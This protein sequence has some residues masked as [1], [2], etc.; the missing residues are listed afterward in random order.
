MNCKRLFS[1]VIILSLSVTFLPSIAQEKNIGED[2]KPA[3]TESADT[4]KSTTPDSVRVPIIPIS[5]IGTID[6][7][8][9]IENVVTDTA[10]NWNDYS[11][12]NDIIAARGNVFIR[13]LGSVGQFSSLSIGGLDERSVAFLHDGI[14]LNEPLT[15]T[16]NSYW[17][18][19]EQIERVEIETG[20]RAFLYGFNSTGGAINMLTKSF[21]AIKPYSRIRYSESLYEQAF[22]DG[23]V[24]QNLTRTLNL[25]LGVQRYT[26]DGRFR[27]SD[28]DA[29]GVRFKARF[30][31]S[32]RWNIFFSEN[33]TQTQLGLFGGVNDTLTNPAFLF[34]RLQAVI[35]NG[36]SYEK[37]TRHDLQL[38]AA[39]QLFEDT[40]DVTTLTAY[41]ST[42]LREFRNEENR[43]NPDGIFIQDN[44]HLHWQGMKFTQHLEFE[45]QSF[46]LGA[47]V[48]SRQIIESPA[49][50][51]RVQTATSV[52][53]KLELQPLDLVR[54]ALYARLDN[55][56]NHSPLSYGGDAT[57]S[58]LQE[59]SL[60]AGYSRSSRFPT[61]QELYWR[62]KSIN[63]PMGEVEPESHSVAEAGTRIHLGDIF[64]FHARY[65]YRIISNAIATDSTSFDAPFP[66]L[67]FVVRDNIQYNG[68]ELF[69]SLR[70]W[71]LYAEGT[72][73]YLSL[74]ENGSERTLF[75]KWWAAGGIYFWD[76]LFHDNL[77]LKVGIRGRIVGPQDGMEFNPEAMMFVPSSLPEL[78]LATAVDGILLAHIGSAYI[79]FIWQNLFDNN[80]VVTPFYPMPDRAVRFGI[81]WEL[82]D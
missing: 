78:G 17:Y 10:A 7:T 14:L 57:L 26:T 33:Y 1:F 8:I 79:H 49:T 23:R 80:Y 32:S 6:R 50:G 73:H 40:T 66:G 54:L 41:Y 13:D 75:P 81:S 69:S 12:L 59:I 21:K 60:F 24:S 29:W 9:S 74:L 64:S 67:Q 61:F 11:Y 44:H 22:F 4:S 55:Y 43:P 34:D 58:P 70:I 36:D 27:N 65:Y 52:N 76:K 42:H 47:E 5:F 68:V 82:L 15:G 18:Q 56:L 48:Q 77:D 45:R 37:I 28:Y 51:Y 31:G 62:T 71:S 46:D 16:Y 19:T 63:G 53:G 38:G 3:R 20:T 39:A 30:N 2:K 35:L 72:A 25:T